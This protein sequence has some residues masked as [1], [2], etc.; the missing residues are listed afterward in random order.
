MAIDWFHIIISQNRENLILIV[1]GHRNGLISIWKNFENENLFIDKYT[2]E[3][4]SLV[5]FEFGIIVSTFSCLYLWD[6]GMQNE[7]R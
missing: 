1:T 7:I 6:I 2:E 3:I 5:N 4:V